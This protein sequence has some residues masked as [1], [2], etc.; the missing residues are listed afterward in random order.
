MNKTKYL[1]AN[2]TE[3]FE[4]WDK[5]HDF[6]KIAKIFNNKAKKEGV[7]LDSPL[8]KATITAFATKYND[9]PYVLSAGKRLISSLWTSEGLRGI[10]A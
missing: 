9:R 1:E 4:K 3:V 6:T 5:G 2:M 10:A 8:S 7:K